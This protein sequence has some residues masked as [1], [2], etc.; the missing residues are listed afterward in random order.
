MDGVE[1]AAAC[2]TAESVVVA[3]TDVVASM[4]GRGLLLS[5]L[6]TSYMVGLSHLYETLLGKLLITLGLHIAMQSTQK[7]KQSLN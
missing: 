3:A 4:T 6:P 2:T 7:N 5:N 1:T